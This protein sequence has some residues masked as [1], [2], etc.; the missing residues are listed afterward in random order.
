LPGRQPRVVI[1]DIYLTFEDEATRQV[2]WADLL[3]RE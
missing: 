1:E 2:V 3:A